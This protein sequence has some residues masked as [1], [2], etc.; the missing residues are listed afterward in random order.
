MDDKEFLYV[1]QKYRLSSL[2]FF[3]KGRGQSLMSDLGFLNK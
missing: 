2:E 1:G 3:V